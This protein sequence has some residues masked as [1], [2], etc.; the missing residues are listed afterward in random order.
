MS[1]AAEIPTRSM[2]RA[3]FYRWAETQPR[4]RFEREDGQVV[5]MAPEREAHADAE[6][7]AWLALRR[8]IE[9]AGAPCKAYVD[10]LAVAVDESTSYEPDALVNCGEAMEPTAL[11]ASNP[12]IVVEV[13][14]PSNSRVD[15]DTKFL[16]DFRVPSIHHY[17]IVH[18][19]KRVVI[20]HRRRDA[21]RIESA[22]L[23][24]GPIALDPPGLEVMVEDVLP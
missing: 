24:S 22:I 14:S 11:A 10:G 1:E 16:G 21:A 2:T 12:V 15:L 3:E 7:L 9:R 8:A 4:G 5:A 18:L 20:H 19:A 23:G 6:A 13:T 17:L